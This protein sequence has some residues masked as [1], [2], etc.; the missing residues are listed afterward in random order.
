MTSV[1]GREA[2]VEEGELFVKICGVTSE[3]DALL[4]VGLGANAVGFIFAPSTR[5]MSPGAVADIVKRLP[6]ET[7][8]VGVFRNEHRERIMEIVNQAGLGAVQL[9]GSESTEDT[10]WVAARVP[11]TI[12]A[13]S[14]GAEAID[15]F[16]E[17]GADYLLIDGPTPGSGQL[18]DWRMAEGVADVHRLIVSGGLD[19]TNVALAIE[20]LRPW[21]VDVASGVEARPGVKDPV[22]L[23]AFMAVAREAAASTGARTGERVDPG[24]FVDRFDQPLGGGKIG[25]SSG[26]TT[27]DGRGEPA[28]AGATFFDWRN[29]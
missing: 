13:F 6:H 8:A 10:R 23:A 19:A 24:D 25:D 7:L 1:F 29:E 14:A 22:R 16:P 4:A 12:K 27:M 5:Q 28:D 20:R 11:C 17:F 9:H 2:L 3:T 21:G 15:H 18:F 26:L